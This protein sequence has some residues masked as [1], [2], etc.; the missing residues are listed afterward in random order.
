MR[1]LA[2]FLSAALLGG[3]GSATEAAST[4]QSAQRLYDDA[5]YTEA[6]AR[7]R[8]ALFSPVAADGEIAAAHLLL[9]KVAA[10]S[11]EASLARAHFLVA[12][13]RRPDISLG[14][15][16]MP[17][18]LLAFDAAQTERRARLEGA[19]RV[20]QSA[21]RPAAG[22]DDDPDRWTTVAV[23]S[24]LAVAVVTVAAGAVITTWRPPCD[25]SL[26]CTQPP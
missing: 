5:L 15:E 2:L 24:V 7:A 25:A 23:V 13:E 16:R 21:P 6:A 9:G 22:P 12:L 20:E 3:A 17:A 8:E 1:A 10:R 11:G 26:G 19:A 4:L 14:G 18:I